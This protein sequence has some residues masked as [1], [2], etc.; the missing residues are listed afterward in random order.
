[1][2]TT[3]EQQLEAA[4]DK[5]VNASNQASIKQLE[6]RIT[7]L[8]SENQKL[9]AACAVKDE[10]LKEALAVVHSCLGED[11]ADHAYPLFELSEKAFGNSDS[12]LKTRREK[13]NELLKQGKRVCVNCWKEVHLLHDHDNWRHVDGG[14]VDC[15]QPQPLLIPCFANPIQVQTLSDNSGQ[16]LLE[17]VERLREAVNLLQPLSITAGNANA[18]SYHLKQG[19]Q[20]GGLTLIALVAWLDGLAQKLNC[21]QQALNPQKKGEE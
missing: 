13:A 19:D 14:R 12:S 6:H 10:A 7:H 15:F 17:E 5:L 3:N 16:D 1:M 2:P 21:A 4:L 20:Y 9:K 11:W 18:I 8:E